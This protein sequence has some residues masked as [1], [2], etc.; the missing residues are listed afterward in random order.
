VEISYLAES[1]S[2]S[3]TGV[4]SLGEI[5]HQLSSFFLSFVVSKGITLAH[6]KTHFR[7]AH[8]AH[9]IRL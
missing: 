3:R 2:F 6:Q 1:Y 5:A 9:M 4:Q 8:N 7:H